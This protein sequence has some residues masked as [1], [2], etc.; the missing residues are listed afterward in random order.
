MLNEFLDLFYQYD[1]VH[2]ITS[3]LTL[4]VTLF[5]AALTY[6]QVHHVMRRDRHSRYDFKIKAD[7]WIAKAKDHYAQE[8]KDEKRL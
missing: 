2:L 1:R 3:M 8:A 6:W 5:S 4:F 7:I